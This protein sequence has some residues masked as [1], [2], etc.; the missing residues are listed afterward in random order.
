MSDD[1]RETHPLD[2]FDEG[3]LL[4]VMNDGSL[5]VQFGLMPPSWSDDEAAFESFEEK[6]SEALE[7][8]RETS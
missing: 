7:L 3:T 2:E 4:L 5:Q 1:V 6:L 8:R